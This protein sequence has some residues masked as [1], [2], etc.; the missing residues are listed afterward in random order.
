MAAVDIAFDQPREVAASLNYVV[1]D[2]RLYR[3][4]FEPPP[5]AAE[6]N[7]RYQPNPVLIHNLRPLASSLSLD[8]Q[9]FELRTHQSTVQDFYAED[10]LKRVYYPEA[11]ALLKAATGAQRVLVFD[12]TIR[13]RPSAAPNPA[14]GVP[15]E[16]V[17]RVHNDYTFKSGPQRVRDLLPEQAAELLQRRFSIINVW[18]P[19]RGPLQDT[20]LALCD[21]RSV[22]PE[23][24]V[25]L[26]LLYR[27]RTGEIFMVRYSSQHRWYYA[28]NMSSDEVLLLKTF[29]SAED[30]RARFSVHAAFEDPNTPPERL[31]R[32][33]IELRALVLHA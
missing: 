7:A 15:R 9:G 11:E 4:N 26:D 30:G 5:G 8:I 25:P 24:L 12:H 22:A 1:P 31:P 33:S 2:G 23:D 27:D 21:A 19:I 32:E 6:T 16:P 28:P 10:E 14:V 13:R 17:P 3:Y 20:P 18:R 29:D